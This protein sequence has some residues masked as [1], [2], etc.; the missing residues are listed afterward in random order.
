M[1]NTTKVKSH[2]ILT[3]ARTTETLWRRRPMSAHHQFIA[4]GP[5]SAQRKFRCE[6]HPRQACT[7]T[8]HVVLDL[9]VPVDIEVGPKAM[10]IG[11][12]GG[13]ASA[14]PCRVQYGK[15]LRY[16]WIAFPSYDDWALS[17][18]ALPSVAHK[19]KVC[20]RTQK[21]V[22]AVWKARYEQARA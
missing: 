4:L 7:N 12:M 1:Q 21:S 14:A 9:C 15:A 17:F 8:L 13:G 5:G 19:R 2:E 16:W 3:G 6:R 20:E 11:F 22:D 10:P 18:F